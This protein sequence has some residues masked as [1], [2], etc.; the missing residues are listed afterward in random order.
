MKMSSPTVDARNTDGLTPRP[1]GKRK[2]LSTLRI[3]DETTQLKRYLWKLLVF[4]ALQHYGTS[5]R[6]KLAKLRQVVSSLTRRVRTFHLHRGFIKFVNHCQ[7]HK[8]SS[9][10]NAFS[11]LC[12]KLES[13]ELELQSLREQLLQRTFDE[14]AAADIAK[15]AI[16]TDRRHIRACSHLILWLI[17]RSSMSQR[18]AAQR[19]REASTSRWYSFDNSTQDAQT[20]TE[21]ADHLNHP[22]ESNQE[23]NHSDQ[24]TGSEP[25]LAVAVEFIDELA[26]DLVRQRDTLLN[27]VSES[28]SELI[29]ELGREEVCEAVVG[30]VVSSRIQLAEGCRH[31][32]EDDGACKYEGESGVVNFNLESV[33]EP[34]VA[35]IAVIDPHVS[36]AA[37]RVEPTTELICDN[38]SRDYTDLAINSPL[39]LPNGIASIQVKNEFSCWGF[40]DAEP[41]EPVVDSTVGSVVEVVDD[42]TIVKE[43]DGNWQSIVVYHEH[44]A[45][46]IQEDSFAI[47]FGAEPHDAEVNSCSEHGDEL[48]REPVRHEDNVLE[49]VVEL[50]VDSVVE[51]LVDL[52]VERPDDHI[53]VGGPSHVINLEQ[54]LESVLYNEPIPDSCIVE[55]DAPVEP[56]VWWPQ[57]LAESSVCTSLVQASQSDTLIIDDLKADLML[58]SSFDSLGSP[59]GSNHT[60]TNA[61]W[62]CIFD[63]GSV[64]SEVHLSGLYPLAYKIHWLTR[65]VW[66]RNIRKSFSFWH[67]HS[68]LSKSLF[69]IESVLRK[70]IRT[71]LHTALVQ[72]E[73]VSNDRLSDQKSIQLSTSFHLEHKE[74]N[75]PH[76]STGELTIMHLQQELMELNRLFM[77]N[78]QQMAQEQSDLHSAL[79]RIAEDKL[80]L[81]DEIERLRASQ[82]NI[83]PE[84]SPA[85]TARTVQHGVTHF[86]DRT[87]YQQGPLPST[88]VLLNGGPQTLRSPVNVN[89]KAIPSGTAESTYSYGVPRDTVERNGPWSSR[90]LNPTVR[91]DESELRSS[92]PQPNLNVFDSRGISS[93][94]RRPLFNSHSVGSSPNLPSSKPLYDLTSLLHRNGLASMQNK[95]RNPSD[96]S[97]NRHV[98]SPQHRVSK[99][100]SVRPLSRTVSLSPKRPNRSDHNGHPVSPNHWSSVQQF[101]AHSNTSIGST[102]RN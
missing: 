42:A 100:P 99:S 27:H 98:V 31:G 75:Q 5:Q 39:N 45:D 51:P 73:T 32:K 53:D 43:L 33:G 77:A 25:A 4:R 87:V 74:L 89:Q 50:A 26:I 18:R 84:S 37:D 17:Q 65:R 59:V 80:L 68:R 30:S 49:P 52:M 69:T 96:V 85:R 54:E 41:F 10:R 63:T 66:R 83:T 79:T 102:S 82:S 92:H 58:Q 29:S 46:L 101:F 61:S 3:F 15:D 62:D 8:L 38:L 64:L 57:Q 95:Q 24:L 2:Q 14:K 81:L 97:P 19:W 48:V 93:A 78:K 11:T 16:Q 28:R 20:N 23:P 56:T 72:L 40:T 21:V 34:D 35:K 88:S 71:D 86:Q 47:P 6:K 67:R 60:S 90:S 12:A 55:S 94:D 13:Q 22:L 36:D 70:R 7:Q 44:S 91:R 9:S 76:E 1:A